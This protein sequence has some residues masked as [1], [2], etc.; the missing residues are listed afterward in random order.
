LWGV[1]LGRIQGHAKAATAGGS[2]GEFLLAV[3]FAIGLA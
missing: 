1:G 3:V 2:E